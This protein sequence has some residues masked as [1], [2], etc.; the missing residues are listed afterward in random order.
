MT[1]AH[2]EA[3]GL[4]EQAV[5]DLMR[6]TLVDQVAQFERK[7]RELRGEPV[8]DT[9]ASE[10]E[11]DS[12][13][14]AGTDRVPPDEGSGETD[15]GPAP[16]DEL[17][18]PGGET[19]P[20]GADDG[21]GGRGGT[22]A[23]QDGGTG[24]SLSSGN[25]PEPVA[26]ATTEAVLPG[27][28]TGAVDQPEAV[29]AQDTGAAR[30]RWE[31]TSPGCGEHHDDEARTGGNQ[32]AATVPAA[33]RPHA[34]SRPGPEADEANPASADGWAGAGATVEALV[35]E[36]RLAE[37]YW[38]SRAAGVSEHRTLALAFADAAFHDSPASASDLQVKA[39]EYLDAVTR[40]R[41]LEDDRDAQFMVLTAAVRSGISAHWASSA[42]TGDH[43]SVPGLPD[44]WARALDGLVLAVRK[45]A[46]ITPG[47]LRTGVAAAEANRFE[48]I[49]DQAR[50]LAVDLPKRKI[51]YQRATVV[52]QTL[53]GPDG[54]LGATLHAVEEWAGKGGTSGAEKL[55]GLMEEHFR[56]IDAADRL[57]DDTDRVKRTTKQAKNDIHSGARLQL[58]THIKSVQDLLKAAL[59]AAEAPA[60]SGSGAIGPELLAALAAAREAGRPPG[61][62][63]ALFDLLVRWLDRSYTPGPRDE[64]IRFPPPADALMM[65]PGLSWRSENGRYLPDVAAPEA[66]PVLADILS[67]HDPA[68]ALA[69]HRAHGDLHLAERLLNRISR[70]EVPGVELT[71]V[72]LA[73]QRQALSD[74]AGQWKD[75]CAKEHRS[76][77]LAL[78]R[79]RAQNLLTHEVEREFTGRLLDLEG[80]GHGGSFGE[81]LRAVERVAEGLR[82]LEQERSDDLRRQLGQVRLTEQDAS[83]IRDLL[84]RGETVAAE[85]L[86]TFARRGQPLPEPTEPAGE[87][88]SRFLSGVARQ[89]AP[90]PDSSG[91]S[92][93]WWADHYASG[94][95]L[96]QNAVSGLDA[97]DRLGQLRDPRK[98]G[99]AVVSV[100]RLLGLNASQPNVEEARWGVTRLSVRADITEST[101]GYVAALGSYARRTYKVVVITDELRGEGPLRHLPASAIEAHII[102]YTQPLGVEGRRS[103]AQESRGR[104]HQALVIDP[105]VVGWVAAH[106]PRSF[107]AVQ[108]VTLPWTGYTPYTP[109]VA[110][111][112]P[113]EVF[114]GRTDEMR[115]VL[116]PQGP[117][118]LFGGGSSAS[119]PCSGRPWRCSRKTTGRTGS[120]CTST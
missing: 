57:I 22:P 100:L 105:A 34:P 67:P 116:D 17:P 117:I 59:R 10:A 47:G 95:A 42:L 113:P 28:G 40:S 63:G 72:Q 73:E 36:G 110:G 78:A 35:A 33:P 23:S 97:W 26:A 53:A 109:H 108:Q 45:G 55:S 49:A 115:A 30:V 3:V 69:W 4:L 8:A 85:E 83:R 120:P 77:Q 86:L 2:D 102:L 66:F 93:R 5:S 75:R 62:G 21:V 104:S 14:G 99:K 107:R 64:D 119:R 1:Q 54:V 89:D 94:E 15:P 65:L 98:V 27:P 70:G 39:E 80:E 31:A 90:R 103:L 96:V 84:D 112:V 79:V 12:A 101:P 13:A 114:K 37:A 92:A 18:G 87:V 68:R 46:E 29:A 106:A 88:L 48:K 9:T 19:S 41:P 11:S 71:A 60:A 81:R 76:A 91:G 20:H 16:Q 52:L 82:L 43:T 38:V 25:T 56:R 7:L 74:A 6:K 50:Q 61:V 32:R 118:F 44:P 24:D 58:R 51:R 111:L